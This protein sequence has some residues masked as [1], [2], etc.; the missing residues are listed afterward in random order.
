MVAANLSDIATLDAAFDGAVAIFCVT[1]FCENTPRVDIEAT[2][3]EE[4]Q[5][6]VT[7]AT[8]ASRLPTL[9]HLVLS[10]M[11]HCN[12]ISG[13][14]FPVPHWYYKAQAVTHIKDTLPQLALK[15]TYVGL[16]W[17]LD[18][19]G[20]LSASRLQPSKPDGIVPVAGLIAIIVGVAV[21]AI[22]DQP[23]STVSI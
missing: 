1:A 2:G 9:K 3:K 12:S 10:V 7:V 13:G 6:F 14:K 16:G 19:M 5:Q 4:F 22:L 21:E 18:N 17:Y 20:K 23:S 15:T 11:P 8:V